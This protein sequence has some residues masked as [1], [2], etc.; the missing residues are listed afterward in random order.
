LGVKE[1]GMKFK[2]HLKQK[3]Q[4]DEFKQL[5]DEEKMLLDLS[6]T[7]LKLRQDKGL[8]QRELADMAHVTQQQ[9]SKAERGIN[10]NMFTFLKICNALGVSVTI[11]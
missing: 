2:E 8:S 9:L 6:L 1:I 3:L 4:D 7:I 10:C 5:Y 11:Q